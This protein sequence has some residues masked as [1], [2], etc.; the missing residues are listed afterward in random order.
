MIHLKAKVLNTIHKHQMILPDEKIILAVSGGPDSTA[1][2]YLMYDLRDELKC[3][4]HIAHLNHNLRGEESDADAEFVKEQA[5]KLGLPITVESLDVKSMISKESLESGARRIRYEFYEKVMSETHA[6]KVVLGHTADDQAETVIMRFLRGSGAKGLSG[7]PPI[8]DDIYIRPLIETSRAEVEEYLQS[9]NITPRWDSSNLSTEYERNK[10]RHELIPLLERNYS[11]NIKHILQQT[12][13]I[14]REEDDFLTEQIRQAMGE[15]IHHQDSRSIDISI[16]ALKKH[17]IALQRRILRLAIES[18][19][20]DLNRYNFDHLVALMDLID[21]NTGKTISL[22]RGIIAERIY[23]KIIIS[24]ESFQQPS[25]PFD[26]IIDVPDEIEIP[27]LGLSVRTILS[28]SDYMAYSKDKFQK[29]FDYDKI[30]GNLHL[31]S[32]RNGDRF[33]PLGVSGT[34]KLKD[35][36][37]DEKVPRSQRDNVPILTDGNNILWIVGYQIDDRFKV[38]TQTKTEL[39]VTVSIKQPP[40]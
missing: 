37:I 36:F 30:K 18:L 22:P 39:N 29:T 16:P 10:I 7:I 5:Q 20:G 32:R 13:D 35:F 6:N 27:D 1:L 40:D 4:L 25:E 24:L 12:A 8:R 38:T 14:L 9:L 19:L 23:D 31:R 15:C 3:S 33:Q 2:L 28:K 21:N 26:Y 17:H 34:K 11:P